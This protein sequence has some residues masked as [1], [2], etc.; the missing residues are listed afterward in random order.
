MSQS[1]VFIRIRH[2]SIDPQEISD[3]LGVEPLHAWAAGSARAVVEDGSVR[4]MHP[5]TYWFG[6]LSGPELLP[7]IAARW[8]VAARSDRA[9]LRRQLSVAIRLAAVTLRLKPR[10]PF[11]E[12]I[13]REGGT[14]DLV[15][16]VSA[17]DAQNLELP[18]E[19]LRALAELQLTLVIELAAGSD[20]GAA[21]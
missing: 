15:V 13:V 17:Q 14:C 16:S 7:S 10:K 3:E 20:R 19:A 4:R 11:L 5:D 8:L 6:C 1:T 2:P 12:R 21:E 9:T 18:P